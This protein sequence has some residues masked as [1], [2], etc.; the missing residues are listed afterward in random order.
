MTKPREWLYGAEFWV[1]EDHCFKSAPDC[2]NAFSEAGPACGFV[3]I[4]AYRQVLKER[5]EARAEVA[6]HPKKL[7]H[8]LSGV[9]G[10]LEEQREQI[11]K[12]EAALQHY[13]NEQYYNGGSYTVDGNIAKGALVLRGKK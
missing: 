6:L 5:D 12:Y 13:A 9:A 1:P 3:G 10:L 4:E 7:A 8:A 11:S 2:L